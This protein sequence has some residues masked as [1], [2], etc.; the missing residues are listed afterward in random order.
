MMHVATTPIKMEPEIMTKY[1]ND[2]DFS[3]TVY[4]NE[5]MK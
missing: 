3:Q 5:M 4:R 2:S 1:I